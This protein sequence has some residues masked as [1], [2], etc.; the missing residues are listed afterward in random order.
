MVYCG[1]WHPPWVRSVLP[2]LAGEGAPVRMPWEHLSASA[3]Q[4]LVALLLHCVP[5]GY[6]P[7]IVLVQLISQGRHSSRWHSSETGRR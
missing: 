6:C 1:D 3:I 4:L 2:L 5:R 7:R